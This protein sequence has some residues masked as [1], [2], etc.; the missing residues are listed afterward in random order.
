MRLRNLSRQKIVELQLAIDVCDHQRATCEAEIAAASMTVA[1]TSA[2][3]HPTSNTEP[4]WPCSKKPT[5]DLVKTSDWS[6]GH[7]AAAAETA[8]EN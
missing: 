1:N 7:S 3:N 8:A 2:N 4:S 6:F 5:W